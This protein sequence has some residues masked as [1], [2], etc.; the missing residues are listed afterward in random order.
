V[1]KIGEGMQK[2]DD[3]GE[4]DDVVEAKMGRFFFSVKSDQDWRRGKKG[5]MVN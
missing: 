2:Y 1:G 4:F 5:K 3:R